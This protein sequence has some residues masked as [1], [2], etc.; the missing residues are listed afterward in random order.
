MPLF[1]VILAKFLKMKHLM[2]GFLGLAIV[3]CLSCCASKAQSVK[4]FPQ[5]F[6]SVYFQ[7]WIG[8]QQLT[9]SGTNFLIEFKKP[10][11]KE[12]KPQKIYFQNQE[13][14][15]KQLNDTLVAAY[16]YQKPNKQD[17]VLNNNETAITQKPKYTLLPNEAVIEYALKGENLFFKI[18]GIKEKELIAYPS[19]RPR[20]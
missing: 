5:E 7:K 6:E 2:K 10:L 14:V 1:L 19:T 20:N 12:I 17:I 4:A 11:S 16:F 3:L 9:G 13:A 15:C 8:G 18:V